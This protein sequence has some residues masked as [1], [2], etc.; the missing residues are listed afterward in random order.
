[1]IPEYSTETSGTEAIIC[2]N[3][4]M[5]IGVCNALEEM[6]IKIPDQVA[7]AGFDTAEEGQLS[8]MFVTSSDM[9]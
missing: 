5:A 9:P 7:V 1:M 8:P 2:A 4:E 3:D 6:G